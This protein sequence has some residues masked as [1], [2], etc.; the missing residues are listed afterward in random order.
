VIIG[1]DCNTKETSSSYRLLDESFDAASYQVGW[2]FPG[3]ELA[4]ARQDVNIQH[5]DFIWYRGALQPLVAYE[6]NDNAG[7]DHQPV[8]ALFD[9]K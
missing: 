3:M 1:C 7:S 8:L 2:R 4:G 9:L 5:I 6:L